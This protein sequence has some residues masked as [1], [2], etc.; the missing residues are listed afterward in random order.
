MTTEI[1][2]E[3]TL[4][5]VLDFQYSKAGGS[6]R[7]IIIRNRKGDCVVKPNVNVRF[8]NCTFSSFKSIENNIFFFRNCTF[9]GDPT[10]FN[11]EKASIIADQ[12]T[13]FETRIR[14]KNSSLQL[15]RTK[16][17]ASHIYE[18]VQLFSYNSVWEPVENSEDT[19]GIFADN[20]R[21]IL[22]EDR[23]SKW[24]EC[25]IKATNKSFIK[26]DKPSEIN[27]NNK[28]FLNI[29]DSVI[30]VWNIKNLK[31]ITQNNSENAVI[32][33]ENSSFLLNSPN[34]LRTNGV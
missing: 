1:N 5:E 23:I 9:K 17:K 7:S 27:T 20:S 31:D 29:K 34:T 18:N 2:N 21:L 8:Y 26:I 30:E 10:N 3:S 25:F 19:V 11:I 6:L 33:L 12:E 13:S 16:N 24:A 28:P 15:M 14:F 22:I 32:T 4:Q